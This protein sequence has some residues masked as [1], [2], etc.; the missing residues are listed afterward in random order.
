MQLGQLLRA[1]EKALGVV[2]SPTKP[3]EPEPFREA[4]VSAEKLAQRLLTELPSITVYVPA[5][6]DA[7]FAIGTTSYPE[8]VV[9]QPVRVDPGRHQVVVRARGFRSEIRMVDVAISQR[10]SLTFQ[11]QPEVAQEPREPSQ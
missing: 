6:V 2:L 3:D 5:G 8:S 4:R 1:R 9:G 11:L 7:T 10:E